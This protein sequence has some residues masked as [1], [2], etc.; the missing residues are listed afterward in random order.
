MAGNKK[1]LQEK[2]AKYKAHTFKWTT[3]FNSLPFRRLGVDLQSCTSC[4]LASISECRQR[5]RR[6]LLKKSVTRSRAMPWLRGIF[7]L[8]KLIIFS[9]AVLFLTRAIAETGFDSRAVGRSR[10]EVW[11]KLLFL[12]CWTALAEL[13]D[14]KLTTAPSWSDCAWSR[15]KTQ[16][17]LLPL[18]DSSWRRHIILGDIDSGGGG[19]D[20]IRAIGRPCQGSLRD[21]LALLT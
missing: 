11:M 9:A 5:T 2:I 6:M 20:G 16:W 12:S 19:N 3:T 17:R 14:D 13:L 10:V 1:A 8:C 7:A 21:L 4:P 18:L 15:P